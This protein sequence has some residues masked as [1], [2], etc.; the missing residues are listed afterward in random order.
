[1]FQSLWPTQFPD[2]GLRRFNPHVQSWRLYKKLSQ[3]HPQLIC[4]T[5]FA[6]INSYIFKRHL[7]YSNQSFQCEVFVKGVFFVCVEAVNSTNDSKA[8][9]QHLAGYQWLLVLRSQPRTRPNYSWRHCYEGRCFQFIPEI[10]CYILDK[11]CHISR[12]HIAGFKIIILHFLPSTKS[13]FRNLL[14]FRPIRINL[15]P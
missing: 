1:M 9:T 5:R 3:S 14:K 2:N 10:Y 8:G 12:S 7:C 11:V 15:F 13:G 4:I 6:K